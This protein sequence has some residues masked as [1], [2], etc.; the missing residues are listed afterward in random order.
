[1][2]TLLLVALVMS[3]LVT[4]ATPASAEEVGVGDCEKF[5][6]ACAGVCVAATTGCEDGRLVC[7]GVSYQVPQCVG[8]A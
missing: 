2:R 3:A 4:L 5:N 7:V 6:G 1:M 8:R